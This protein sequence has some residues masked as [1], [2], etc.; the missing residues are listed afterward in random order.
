MIGFLDKR[1]K[2]AAYFALLVLTTCVL[3]FKDTSSKFLGFAE[4][5]VS[6]GADVLCS[7]LKPLSI[8]A[9][10]KHV[11]PTHSKTPCEYIF[12]LR[13]SSS[14]VEGASFVLSIGALSRHAAIEIELSG[15][16][17]NSRQFKINPDSAD[18]KEYFF[19]IPETSSL[20]KLLIKIRRISGGVYIRERVDLVSRPYVAPRS[21]NRFLDGVSYCPIAI[22]LFSFSI[23]AYRLLFKEVGGFPFLPTAFTALTLFFSNRP[24]YY[25]DEW[26]ILER[27]SKLGFSGVIHTHNEHSIVA[28]FAWYYFLVNLF[29]ENYS[30]LIVVSVLLHVFCGFLIE[31][32]LLTYRLDKK[33]VRACSLFFVFSSLHVEVLHW[34]FEQCIIFSCVVALLSFVYLRTWLLEGRLKDLICSAL[35]LTISPLFFGNGFIFL[36][37]AFLIVVFH[38]G[39]SNIKNYFVVGATLGVPFL[40]PVAIFYFLKHA[41]AGHGVDKIDAAFSVGKYLSYILTGTGLG[42]LARGIGFYP[43]L[44]LSSVQTF[45]YE[46]FGQYVPFL[47][48][49]TL[50]G[51]TVEVTL[52]LYFWSLCLLII[53]LVFY[54][55]KGSRSSIGVVLFGLVVVMS[56]FVLPAIG[57][58]SLGDLQAMSLRYQYSSLIGFAIM[59]YPIFYMLMDGKLVRKIFFTFMVLWGVQQVYLVSAFSY[60]S[61]FGVVHRVYAQQVFD[62]NKI[63][64][65]KEGLSP[66]HRPTI[67]P[68][69]T[70]EDI[71]KTYKW[72]T[73]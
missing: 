24:F 55:K 5:R 37:L 14:T 73:R 18:V 53:G 43:N 67:T 60:F 30:L 25:F 21:I 71:A 65:G 57:R 72:L 48:K 51:S 47:D 58:A 11:W 10:S 52:G 35:F 20:S 50:F 23:L 49:N 39:I 56:S 29:R 12:S 59:L 38:Y 68:G 19:Q 42:T 15:E 22:F 70:P 13:E 4:L 7:E 44:T 54:F 26:H 69:S 27:F 36:P 9:S 6:P 17:F 61:D 16:D 3:F 45:C 41:S 34:A 31:K 66:S 32:F 40:G 64:Q 62:W 2:F 33:V 46:V 1:R 63:T 8:D 28:F